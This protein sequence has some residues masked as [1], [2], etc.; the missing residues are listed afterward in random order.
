MKSEMP[1]MPSLP[2]TAISA[3]APFSITYSSETMAVVGKYTW[4]KV[5]PDSYS[6]CPSGISTGSSSGSQRCHSVRQRGEQLV[7]KGVGG[8]RHGAKKEIQRMRKDLACSVSSLRNAGCAMPIS[9]RA[10][11]FADLPRNWATPYS[12]TT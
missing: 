8:L 12:V 9:S 7:F 1:T 4:L 2:T 5:R 10:R 6:T 11:C 3:E